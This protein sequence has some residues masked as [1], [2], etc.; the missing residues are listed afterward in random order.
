MCFF[1]WELFKI[2]SPSPNKQIEKRNK[3]AQQRL[4]DLVFMNY[5]RALKRRYDARDRID[6]ISLKDI[7][8]SNEWLMGTM[9]GESDQEDE[10]VFDDEYLT[11]GEVARASGVEEDIY[12]TRSIKGKGVAS[13]STSK[14]VEKTSSQ[15]RTNAPS[16]I[17]EEEIDVEEDEKFDEEDEKF[18]EEDDFVEFSDDL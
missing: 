15:R 17:I 2:R 14:H 4:N 12:S 1:G 3:L 6:P 18:D 5:N 13:T 11:W 7:D 10:L 16:I 8:D 9:E